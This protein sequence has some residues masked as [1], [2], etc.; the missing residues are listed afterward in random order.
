[1]QT[2]NQT[3]NTSLPAKFFETLE[4]EVTLAREMITIIAEE[5]KALVAMDMPALIHLSKKKST[6]AVRIQSLDELA[7]NIARE[8]TANPAAKSIKLASLTPLLSPAQAATLQQ[9]RKELAKLQ[10]MIMTGNQINKHFA[11]DVKKYLNDAISL[12]TSA[13]AERPIYNLKGVNKQASVR[14]PT[15]ISR[16]V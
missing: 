13:A 10:E 2:T 9:Y 15:F 6:H 4:Q 12:I 11:E 7:Q 1:M 8:I 16:E 3:A 5:K 14:Q